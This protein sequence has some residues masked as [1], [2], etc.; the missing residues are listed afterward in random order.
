MQVHLWNEFSDHCGGPTLTKEGARQGPRVCLW[1]FRESWL[2]NCGA[3][4]GQSD[5]SDLLRCSS[6]WGSKSFYLQWDSW[7]RRPGAPCLCFSWTYLS[8]WDLTFAH[9]VI[10]SQTFHSGGKCLR[11]GLEWAC[12]DIHWPPL[13]ELKSGLGFLPPETPKGPYYWCLIQAKATIPSV[14]STKLCFN[15]R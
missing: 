1:T 6:H 15:S 7:A 10:S 5:S 3:G 11:H 14:Q 4:A 2:P 9:M 13:W 8:L 12:M